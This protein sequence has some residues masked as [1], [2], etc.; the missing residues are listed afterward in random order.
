[1]SATEDIFKV[2]IEDNIG[3]I[4][5]DN[6]YI[7]Y[8][9][10]IAFITGLCATHLAINTYM[11]TASP[12]EK[13]QYLFFEGRKNATNKIYYLLPYEFFNDFFQNSW[14]QSIK[15]YYKIK[16]FED[17]DQSPIDEKDAFAKIFLSLGQATYI[18]YWELTK[19]KIIQLFGY[20]QS[21]WNNLLQFGWI[22]RNALAHNFRITVNNNKIDNV[23]WNNLSFGYSTN[24]VDISEQIMFLELVILM[25]DIEDYLKE[26]S[27]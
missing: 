3:F 16:T 18:E 19:V 15:L 1:M 27:I 22:I 23:K 26:Y 2:K 20:D 8:D 17:Q 24:G 12:Y 7:F 11:S 25:K 14:P 21:K 5:I 4:E 13:G 10:V 9:G 6:S